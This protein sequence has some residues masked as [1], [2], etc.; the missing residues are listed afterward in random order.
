MRIRNAV[1]ENWTRRYGQAAGLGLLLA[2]LV[3]AVAAQTQSY[4][5]WPEV[6]TYLKVN[7]NFRASFFAANTKENRQGTDAEVG[8]NIDFFL[9][10]LIKLKR[11]TI[12]D[13]DQSKD[14]PLML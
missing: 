1:L 9:K 12:F 8:P 14:R 4:Q 5:T 10:P 13:L 11:I 3:P 6:D 2:I 7:S